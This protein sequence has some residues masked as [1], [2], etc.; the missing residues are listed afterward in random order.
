MLMQYVGILPEVSTSL[1]HIRK[2][3]CGGF[4]RGDTLKRA[5]RDLEKAIGS[6][7]IGKS[8]CLRLNIISAPH[9]RLCI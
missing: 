5:M 6:P 7:L 3:A 9:A 4:L 2:N 1:K 8:D